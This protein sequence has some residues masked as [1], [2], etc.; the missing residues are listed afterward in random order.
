VNCARD[1]DKLDPEAPDELPVPE[2]VDVVGEAD[3]ALPDPP[4]P[5]ALASTA[6]AA[7]GRRR[8]R[9]E[10]WARLGTRKFFVTLS[11]PHEHT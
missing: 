2:L 5:Q 3:A 6:T 11:S 10:R 4:P 8:S 7:R 1:A 9:A